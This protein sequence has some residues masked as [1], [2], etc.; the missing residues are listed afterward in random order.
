MTPHPDPIDSPRWVAASRTI[1]RL[2]AIG[3]LVLLLLIPLGM[4]RSVLRERQSSR[5]QAVA[6]I[7]GSW[8]AEQVVFGPV[9]VV[10][11]RY[12]VKVVREE[13][14]NGVLQRREVLQT[15][16]ARASFLPAALR[17]D[18]TLKPNRRYRGIYE[19]VVY[20]AALR[21]EGEFTRPDFSEWKVAAE[22]VLWGDAEL[23]LGVSDLRG[24]RQAITFDCGASRLVSV[25]ATDVPV[26]ESGVR[27]R[28]GALPELS[29]TLPAG[30]RWHFATTLS[31]NGSRDLQFAPVGMS[32]R[33]E[34][35]SA[36]PDPSFHGGFLPLTREID[37]RGFRALWDVSY[38]GRKFPQ[39][40]TTLNGGDRWLERDGATHESFFGVSLLS[41][42][43]SY[44]IVERAIKYGLLIIVLT[45][46]LF[47]LVETLAAIRIHPFQ[48]TL[49]GAAL[50]L[51]Y[52]A[53]LSLSEF[54]PVGR[55]YAAGAAACCVMI[56]L[57]MARPLGRASR[58]LGL[59]IG[60]AALYA[61]LYV[62]LQAQD[63]SL[64]IGTAGLFVALALVMVAT[65]RVDWY[66]RDRR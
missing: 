51:F 20:E 48:Y 62:V 21:L 58:S 6:E 35:A 3:G 42:V 31:L 2:M 9:L 22:D 12:Q 57:Y 37:A 66:A 23:L 50:C 10:P 26:T 56:S 15:Q 13:P 1:F 43:D 41:L 45:F 65:R 4:I 60:L 46:T 33:V 24:T 14:V 53:F 38:Y 19:A 18:G 63:Y 34:L 27:V 7:A 54:W 16:I 59:F 55:A 5:N 25:P 61:F 47:F 44:R 36:W 29:P 28:V 40:W 30:V 32:N 39:Q 64:V 17:I 52:L 49:V 11:F 8:G